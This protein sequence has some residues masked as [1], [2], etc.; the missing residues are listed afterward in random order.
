MKR[1]PIPRSPCPVSWDCMSAPIDHLKSLGLRSWRRGSNPHHQFGENGYA[2]NYTT[3]TSWANCLSC[4]TSRNKDGEVLW[5]QRICW[6]EIV[7]GLN[8]IVKPF[9]SPNWWWEKYDR[10]RSYFELYSPWVRTRAWSDVAGHWLSKF[11]LR[12]S[13]LRWRSEDHSI[14]MRLV[15]VELT[16]F[17]TTRGCSF[18][19]ATVAPDQDMGLFDSNF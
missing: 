8:W 6:R 18:R 9:Y 2:A 11:A 1:A 10:K 5:K 15:K 3:P 19:W 4:T 14:Y 16:T 12:W 7:K 13:D 17:P